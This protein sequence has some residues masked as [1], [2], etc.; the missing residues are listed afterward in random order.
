MI[1]HRSSEKMAKWPKV[2]VLGSHGA[3][4][5]DAPGK[6]KAKWPSASFL[7]G[8]TRHGAERRSFLAVSLDIATDLIQKLL[9]GHGYERVH[10]EKH[11]D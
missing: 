1:S 4:S 5:L 11:Q 8:G 10:L 7:P 2:T 3:S 9:F 6:A